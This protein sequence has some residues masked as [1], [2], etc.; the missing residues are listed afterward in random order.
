MAVRRCLTGVA[1]QYTGTA[2]K[3][4]D[5]RIAISV[6]AVTDTCSAALNWRL[7]LPQRW[8]D[9]PADNVRKDGGLLHSQNGPHPVS[10]DDDVRFSLVARHPDVTGVL[11]TL[12]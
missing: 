12:P 9:A 5:R 6:H 10:L 7:F 3:V 11:L 8:D 1:R 2:G 4:T